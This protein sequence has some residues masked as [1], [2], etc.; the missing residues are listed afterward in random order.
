MDVW[1]AVSSVK[2][3]KKWKETTDN[4]F[5]PDVKCLFYCELGGNPQQHYKI[6]HEVLE[7]L[8]TLP[9]QLDRIEVRY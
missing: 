7:Y 9:C 6:M 3:T 8:C 4:E 2:A 1:P 5:C